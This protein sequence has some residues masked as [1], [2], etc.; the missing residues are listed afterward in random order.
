MKYRVLVMALFVITLSKWN[1]S[2]D[3][4]NLTQTTIITKKRDLRKLDYTMAPYKLSRTYG[5]YAKPKTSL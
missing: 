5:A 2:Y 3:I 1:N 4:E